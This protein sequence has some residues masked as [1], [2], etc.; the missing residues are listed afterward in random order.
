MKRFTIQIPVNQA[1]ATAQWL[2]ENEIRLLLSYSVDD[3]FNAK[4]IIVCGVPDE[5]VT[6]FQT[7]FSKVIKS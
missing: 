6:I 1:D 5:K 3:F 4:I 7:Q 2:F